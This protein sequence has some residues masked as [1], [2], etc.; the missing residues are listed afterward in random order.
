LRSVTTISS[1]EL[2]PSAVAIFSIRA[3]V[4]I[5][6]PTLDLAHVRALN[7]SQTCQFFLSNSFFHARGAH[8]FPE[9]QCWL[10]FKCGGAWGTASLNCTLLH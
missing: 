4:G 8:R 3:S 6:S 10:G 9:G 7:S 5:L 2:I 1:A